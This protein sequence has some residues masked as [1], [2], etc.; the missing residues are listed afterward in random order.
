VNGRRKKKKKAPSGVAVVL[1][2][3][4][5]VVGIVVVVVVVVMGGSVDV[6]RVDALVEVA[7]RVATG[8]PFMYL[9][10]PK[11]QKTVQIHFLK[12]HTCEEDSIPQTVN[13]SNCLSTSLQSIFHPPSSSM[14][15]RMHP[16]TFSLGWVP[17]KHSV[18]SYAKASPPGLQA[19]IS[20]SVKRR[21]HSWIPRR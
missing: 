13:P 15:F 4:V 2:E 10:Q 9:Y 17:S 14:S 20:P 16:M 6:E 8:N 21:F 18:C 7:A 5:V 11:S 12:V 1:D 3:L 19:T